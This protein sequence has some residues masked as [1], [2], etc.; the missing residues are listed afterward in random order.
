MSQPIVHL[1]VSQAED[2]RLKGV[3]HTDRGKPLVFLVDDRP[4]K[5]VSGYGVNYVPLLLPDPAEKAREQRQPPGQ[6]AF[7]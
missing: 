1:V 7:F 6:E 2:I 4:H 5:H 3:G